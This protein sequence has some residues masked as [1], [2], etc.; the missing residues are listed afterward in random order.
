MKN[1][2]LT[3]KDYNLIEA[4]KTV[5]KMNFDDGVYRHTVG[6]AVMCSNGK[7]YSGVNCDGIHGSCA[8]FI[9]I[10]IAISAGERDFEVIVAVNENAQN[11]LIPPC[12]NSR[13]M[14]LEYSPDIKVILNAENGEASKVDIKALL[15]LAWKPTVY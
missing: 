7:V 6:A 12:G 10:G 11:S 8:E 15:P 3:D 2:P 4:A 5:L 14:L 9:A 1:Y 13:Q